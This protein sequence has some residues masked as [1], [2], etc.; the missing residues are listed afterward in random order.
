MK[1]MARREA[2]DRDRDRRRRKCRG[3]GAVRMACDSTRGGSKACW[4]RAR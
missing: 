4:E 1:N 3:M 2:R